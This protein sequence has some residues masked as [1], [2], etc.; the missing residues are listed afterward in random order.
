MSYR[1]LLLEGS[2]NAAEQVAQA[3]GQSFEHKFELT[4]VLRLDVAMERVRRES[5]DLILSDLKLPDS[6]GLAT[7]RSLQSAAPY[8]PIV[9]VA[10]T[11]DDDVAVSV[12]REGADDYLIRGELSGGA[13]SRAVRHAIER[14]Q[15]MV[16]AEAA[17]EDEAR[18]IAT[19]H[20]IGT[21]L[22]AELDMQRVVQL[23]TDEATAL[24][25]AAF[26]AFFY[27]VT[28]AEGDAYMLYT[29]SGVPREAFASFP[30]PRSTP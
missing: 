10:G 23:V 14:R 12:L 25:G 3:L 26:G 9:I 29:L 5:F 20:R 4:H 28:N 16:R 6:Q 11:V 18:I 19:L 21:S 8:C 1:I 24:I 15:A 27:N 13:L 17:L 30:M 2:E 22:T 7:V